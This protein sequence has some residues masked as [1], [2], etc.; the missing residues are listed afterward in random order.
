MEYIGQFTMKN[1]NRVT[2]ANSHTTI[3]AQMNAFAVQLSSDA[4]QEPT[5]NYTIFPVTKVNIEINGKYATSN[6]AKTWRK[7]HLSPYL[8]PCL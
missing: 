1:T 6:S 5:T 4:S 8:G 7:A 2:T 3:P